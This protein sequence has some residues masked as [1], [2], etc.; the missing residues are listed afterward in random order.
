[1]KDRYYREQAWINKKIN[2]GITKKELYNT[3]GIFSNKSKQKVMAEKNLTEKEYD[4][5]YK[6]LHNVFCLL[7]E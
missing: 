2:Q 4:K 7:D 3:V 1:M 6:F 5:R